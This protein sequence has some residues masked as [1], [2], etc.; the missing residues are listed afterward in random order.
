MLAEMS[1]FADMKLRRE[2]YSLSDEQELLR[3]TYARM[4]AARSPMARVRAVESTES[5][6]DAE[7]WTSFESLGVA[8]M[9]LAE[10]LGGDGAGLV[11]LALVAGEVGRAAATAPFVEAT[12]LAR[13]AGRIGRTLGGDGVA[14][15]ALHATTSGSRQLLSFGGVA[16]SAV[17]LVDGALVIVDGSCIERPQN[18]ARAPLGRWEFAGAPTDVLVSGPDASWAHAEAVLDWKLLTASA[19]LGL[20]RSAHDNAVQYAK[21]RTAFGLPIGSYQ[22]ISHPLANLHAELLAA[23]R[24]VLKAAWFRDHEPDAAPELVPLAYV[25]AIEIASRTVSTTVHVQG[26]F[27]VTV[28]S[29]QQIYYRR[30][31]G[32]PAL[33]GDPAV[34]VQAI[35][36]HV[37]RRAVS[38]PIVPRRMEVPS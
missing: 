4:L 22:A 19:V 34:D 8:S 7:L 16:T 33:A 6:F 9:G 36:E 35:A 23:R 20:A 21:D 28:D 37:R 32:W 26:G 29:D 30:V 18:I 2:D 27:G 11:E 5:R 1:E 13:L 10:Q 3:D 38:G 14:T 17:A 15:I 12:V 24:L 31:K 25:A